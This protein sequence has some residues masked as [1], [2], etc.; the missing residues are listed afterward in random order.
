MSLLTRL[1]KAIEVPGE[2]DYYINDDVRPLPASRRTWTKSTFFWFWMATSIN[3]GGLTGA[4]AVLSLVR[5]A[6]GR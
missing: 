1:N 5:L 4:S 2:H 6:C 3:I